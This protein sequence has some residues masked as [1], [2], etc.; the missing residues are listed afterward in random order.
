M[1]LNCKVKIYYIKYNGSSNNL[2]Y[3]Q[4]LRCELIGAS[5]A[6]VA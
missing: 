3:S 6:V 5:I 4:L 2:Y 1:L